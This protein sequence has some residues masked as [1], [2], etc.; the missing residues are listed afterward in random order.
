[1]NC[2]RCLCLLLL[3]SA[4]AAAFAQPFHNLLA[5][6]SLGDWM[7]TN[8]DPVTAGWVIEDGG[9]LHLAGRGGNIIT[10]RQYGDFELWFE[11]RIA[12]KGNNGLKY[13]VRAYDRQWLGIE[14]QILDDDAFPRLTRDHLTGSLYDL[15]APKPDVTRLNPV[16]EWNLGKIQIRNQR[17]RHWVNGQLL[18]DEP[19]CG[20][21]WKDRVAAS[22][23]SKREEFGENVLGHIMLTDHGGEVWYRNVFIRSLDG[24]SCR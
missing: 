21:G 16:G 4:P 17:V 11:F 20:P 10:R 24:C 23:F 19:L 9:V 6:R 8:G 13:R 5:D 1:M 18:I 14:Y 22:K 7:K 2:F 12:P 3:A 15:A